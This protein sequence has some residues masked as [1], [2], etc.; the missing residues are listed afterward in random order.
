[1][2]EETEKVLGQKVGTE[3][4][5]VFVPPVIKMRPA[6]NAISVDDGTGDGAEHV[7]SDLGLF[8]RVDGV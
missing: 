2:G 6:V 7:L 4:E 8:E 5:C 3:A 1:M